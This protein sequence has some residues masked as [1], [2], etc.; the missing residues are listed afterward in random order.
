MRRALAAAALGAAAA[1]HPAKPTQ[2]APAPA[3]AAA[4]DAGPP[5]DPAQE[6]RDLLASARAQRAVL[7]TD[8]Q[9]CAWDAKRA[10]ERGAGIEAVYLEAVCTAAWARLQGFTPLIERRVE[11]IEAF[12]RA[13]K[14]APDLDGAG[15]DRELGALLAA[16]PAYAG[17]DLELAR[18]HLED[19]IRRAPKDARNRLVLARSVAVKAQDRSLFREQL[20]AVIDGSDQ[21]AVAE[22][23]ALL[24]RESEL[25][26]EPQ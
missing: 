11:L 22:A 1:C 26:A 16:L 4:P 13:A 25:F 18:K 8:A 21:A 24:R 3:R 9:G 6:A 20:Q 19:A 5:S 12:D 7:A 15:P 2:P 17:G 10:R 23:S 14:E